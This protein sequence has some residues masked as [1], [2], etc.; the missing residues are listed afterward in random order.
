M[1]RCASTARN[2]CSSDKSRRLEAKVSRKTIAFLLPQTRSTRVCKIRIPRLRLCCSAMD[3]LAL[4]RG[5]CIMMTCG[6]NMMGMTRLKLCIVQLKE[7]SR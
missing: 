5:L 4:G 2:T 6:T 1:K 7:A 3:M